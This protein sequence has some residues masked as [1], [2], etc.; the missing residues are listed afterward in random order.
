MLWVCFMFFEPL[1]QKIVISGDHSDLLVESPPIIPKRKRKQREHPTFWNLPNLIRQVEL[2]GGSLTYL[3][4]SFDDHASI[5]YILQQMMGH[6][7]WGC[8]FC[9]WYFCMLLCSAHGK[10]E[11]WTNNPDHLNFCWLNMFCF[12]LAHFLSK[13]DSQSQKS[14]YTPQKR[15]PLKTRSLLQTSHSSGIWETLGWAWIFL[16]SS[17]FKRMPIQP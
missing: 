16:P 5:R 9:W 4:V 1:D 13:N 2:Q 8:C 17:T 15:D 12:N 11:S 10:L 7:P 3:Y 14:G 6:V